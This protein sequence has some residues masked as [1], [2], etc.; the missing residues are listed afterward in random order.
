MG[1][2][3][4]TGILIDFSIRPTVCATLELLFAGH[5]YPYVF[6]LTWFKRH[7]FIAGYHITSDECAHLPLV[8]DQLV[9]WKLTTCGVEEEIF[10]YLVGNSLRA[11]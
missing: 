6:P 3:Q 10:I 2:W 8:I 4:V 5:A 1:C 9:K 11:R 7:P